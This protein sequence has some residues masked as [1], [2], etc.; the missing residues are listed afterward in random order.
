MVTDLKERDQ[1]VLLFFILK[2]RAS[3]RFPSKNLLTNNPIL[4]HDPCFYE[5]AI[6]E[7]TQ[8]GQQNKRQ[9]LDLDLFSFSL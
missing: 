9:L 4:S 6:F 5:L 2:N 3:A 8:I 7:Q 1:W